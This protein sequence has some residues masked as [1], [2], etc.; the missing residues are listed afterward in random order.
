L[1]RLLKYISA[2]F[3][4]IAGLI[5]IVHLVIP[6]DHHYNGLYSEQDLKCPLKDNQAGDHRGFPLHCNA[7]NDFATDRV[8]EYIFIY[9]LHNFIPDFNCDDE[10]LFPPYRSTIILVTNYD[11][12][13]IN[14]ILFDLFLLRAPPALA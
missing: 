14:P 6:H 2:L 5:L 7:F 10:L 9:N 12:P 11:Q 8:I 1:N 3:I 4:C 13:P